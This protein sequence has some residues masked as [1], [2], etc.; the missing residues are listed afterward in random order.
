[1]KRRWRKKKIGPK[2]C[3]LH[4]LLSPPLL[5]FLC[6][7]PRCQTPRRAGRATEWVRQ[8]QKERQWKE[9]RGSVRAQWLAGLRRWIG[10]NSPGG[11]CLHSADG[12]NK[13]QT[14]LLRRLWNLCW[15]H[16]LPPTCA[17]Q[18]GLRAQ[19]RKVCIMCYSAFGNVRLYQDIEKKMRIRR[20]KCLYAEYKLHLLYLI[21]KHRREKTVRDV[22]AWKLVLIYSAL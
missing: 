19:R 12:F 13:G 1:M 18:L 11:G 10:I 8:H 21:S 2:A 4:L 9:R 15:Y 7:P 16:T 14:T 5:L 22:C 17:V 6:A 20:A 3:L